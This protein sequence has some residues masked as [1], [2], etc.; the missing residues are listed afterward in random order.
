VASAV[1]CAGCFDPPA[2]AVARL[3]EVKREGKRMDAALDNV[4]DRLL[5]N[6]GRVHLWQE[7][8]ARRQ[9]VS[10]VACTVANEHIQGMVANLDKQT[11]KAR[12]L[13]RPKRGGAILSRA[14]PVSYTKRRKL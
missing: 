6:Q 14:T 11:E 2:E 13:K 5:G 7:L 10:A 1:L 4:E 12:R 3:E 8:S 9:Q